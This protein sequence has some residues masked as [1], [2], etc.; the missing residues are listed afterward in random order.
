MTLT[1]FFMGIQSPFGVSQYIYENYAIGGNKRL[2]QMIFR[3]R[4]IIIAR[5]ISRN[6]LHEINHNREFTTE[7][8]RTK[9]GERE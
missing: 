3:N 1:V 6:Q 7:H 4:P 9:D 2:S 5:M 8:K